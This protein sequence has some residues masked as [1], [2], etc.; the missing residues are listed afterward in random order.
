[1]TGWA[2]AGER[3]LRIPQRI[4]HRII[5]R[6]VWRAPAGAHVALVTYEHEG[7]ARQRTFVIGEPGPD[8]RSPMKELP[9]LEAARRQAASAGWKRLSKKTRRGTR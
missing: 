8:G 9:S 3:R 7:N 1:M 5:A 2:G 4:H 6:D